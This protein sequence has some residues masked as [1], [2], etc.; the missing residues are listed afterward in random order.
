MC[1]YG[2]ICLT[3]RCSRID[4]SRSSFMPSIYLGLV[5]KIH[6]T[7]IYAFWDVQT[8]YAPIFAESGDN[9]AFYVNQQVPQDFSD[10]NRYMA[11][12]GLSLIMH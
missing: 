5:C 1:H 2:G 12:N 8:N 11:P 6:Q 9:A 4:P 7:R 3:N 10:L